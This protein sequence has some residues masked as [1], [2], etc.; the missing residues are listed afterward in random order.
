MSVLFEFLAIVALIALRSLVVCA[1]FLAAC[2][3][4][5]MAMLAAMGL[6]AGWLL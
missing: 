3:G 2:A 5:F 6:F 4:G 1:I